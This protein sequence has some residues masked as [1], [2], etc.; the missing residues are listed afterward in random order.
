MLTGTDLS[1]LITLASVG[2][3]QL[4]GKWP[5]VAAE[6]IVEL[7][8]TL[9]HTMPPDENRIPDWAEDFMNRNCFDWHITASEDGPCAEHFGKCP[10]LA[11]PH[12]FMEI[13]GDVRISYDGPLWVAINIIN[14]IGAK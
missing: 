2:A 1:N 11:V 10:G 3:P 14:A 7:Y 5:E 9:R 4:D 12:V 8:K 13:E 6:L